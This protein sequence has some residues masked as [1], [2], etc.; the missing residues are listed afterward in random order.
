MW[1]NTTDPLLIQY[2]TRSTGV[3]VRKTEKT[4]LCTILDA[5]VCVGHP[6]TTHKQTQL[7]ADIGKVQSVLSQGWVPRVREK[8]RNAASGS[9]YSQIGTEGRRET[10][11]GGCMYV[12]VC[13]C[14][15]RGLDL[16]QPMRKSPEVAALTEDLLGGYILHISL[17]RYI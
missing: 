4:N 5:G 12:C 16:R 14:F 13:V 6:K 1:H 7:H 10:R 11:V 9:V 15:W 17:R 8:N 2:Q 3:A